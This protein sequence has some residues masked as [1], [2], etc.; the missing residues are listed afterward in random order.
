MGGF[1]PQLTPWGRF[2]K[3]AGYS[4]GKGFVD[5]EKANYLP[6]GLLGQAGLTWAAQPVNSQG[7]PVVTQNGIPQAYEFTGELATKLSDNAGIFYEYQLGNT[8]PGW[9]GSSGAV[10]IRATHFFHPNGAELLVGIDS[11][12]NPTV[13]DVWN[14]APD[15]SY[16]FYS[17]P[18]SQSA[19]ASP[20]LT[21]LDSQAGSI[22]VYALLNRH[23]YTEIS[24][25]RSATDIFRFM[26]AG[27][28][29][30]AGGQNY[31]K[32]FNP[33]WRAYWTED[34]GPHSLMI[35]GFGMHSA[36]Y[37]DSASPTGPT[38]LF[39]DFG[40]DSQ[41][42]YLATSHKV[43]L[44]GSYIYE[45]QSWDASFP[46]GSS[47]TPK[48]NMKSLNLNAAYTY[49]NDWN[50][51]VGYLETDGS[52]NSALFETQGPQGTGLSSSPKTTAYQLEVDRT[53]S[54]NIQLML[55]YRGFLRYDGLRHNIDGLGRTAADNN[56]LWLSVFYAF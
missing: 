51:G 31:L 13:Q 43:T 29:F 42:Q 32:G 23:V 25:Y 50:F 53:I 1:W 20:M 15:W 28:S 6:V 16:P 27:T 9:K 49:Q 18:Q 11:N 21:N 5:R 22:G 8:F 35:G 33:Y 4:V 30:K 26:S 34:S 36:V 17:S 40:V 54:Q 56:T 48:G 44:R 14:S 19:P 39:T 38:D 52:R 46:L 37:P 41:Y 12:N 24:F 55:Q 7:Q 2:F 10:D 45:K 3:L 47:A